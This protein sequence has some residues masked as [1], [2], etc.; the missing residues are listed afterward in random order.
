[1]TNKFLDDDR[2][3]PLIRLWEENENG[4]IVKAN[5]IVNSTIYGDKT[6]YKI[7]KKMTRPD[8]QEWTAYISVKFH[9][10]QPVPNG[11]R[12][13]IKKYMEGG[14]PNTRDKYNFVFQI[15][16]FD[17]EIIESSDEIAKQAIQEFNEADTYSEDLPF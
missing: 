2:I 14:Y 8:G 3:T 13:R 5:Y 9:N 4:D 16:I 1:M 10:C 7:P 17:Y 15:V 6:F 12:I 11:T